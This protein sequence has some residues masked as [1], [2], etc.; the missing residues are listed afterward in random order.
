MATTSQGVRVISIGASTSMGVSIMGSL[1]YPS[2]ELR[3]VTVPVTPGGTSRISR[4]VPLRVFVLPE[5]MRRERVHLLMFQAVQ[6]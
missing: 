4:R 3:N 5:E 6:P 2:K 1:V